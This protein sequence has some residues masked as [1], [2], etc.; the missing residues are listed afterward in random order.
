MVDCDKLDDGCEGGLP[1]NAY[2]EIIRL[3]GLD[4]ETKYPYD[5]EDEK[6]S[7]KV[8]DARIY[9]NSSV[10]ISSNEAG[11]ARSQTMCL[12]VFKSGWIINIT[13]L[14]LLFIYF[15]LFIYLFI[16][17]ITIITFLHTLP[18]RYCGGALF[19]LTGLLHP[20]LI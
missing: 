20:A 19:N 1:T 9:I 5:G 3:G 6:C 11:K 2:K 8:S 14:N 17:K 10:N 4:T 16:Y 13:I 12:M 15:S 7:F 18:S